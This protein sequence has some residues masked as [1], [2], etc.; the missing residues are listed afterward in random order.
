VQANSFIFTSILI[1]VAAVLVWATVTDLK[2]RRIPNLIPLAIIGLFA[3]FAAGQLVMGLDWK[4]SLV[5]PV[6]AAA[7][8]FAAGVALF[9]A[10]LMGGGD[11]KLMAATALF[12]GPALSL[13][14]ILYVTLAGG[15]VALATL[16]HARM[17]SLEPSEAK[18]PYGVAITAGGLWVCF[19]RFSMLS[20]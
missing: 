10:G 3:A 13:S 17:Q 20:A 16:M 11:V 4:T 7:L 19:Q 2:S 14:F 1:A 12:A 5:W 15:L 18:V 6:I 8:V 9:A